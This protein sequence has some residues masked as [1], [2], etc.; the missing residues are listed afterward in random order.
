MIFPPFYHLHCDL[1]WCCAQLLC[2]AA[3][4]MAGSHTHCSSQDLAHHWHKTQA[5]N[6]QTFHFLLVICHHHLCVLEKTGWF[7]SVEWKLHFL[8]VRAERKSLV[9]RNYN[10]LNL[11]RGVC[12][13]FFIITELIFLERILASGLDCQ[14]KNINWGW[15]WI[16]DHLASLRV[17]S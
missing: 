9:S 15:K 4:S 1:W 16:L 2:V 17:C 5:F 10:G 7:K 12:F 13:V 6:A 14:E 3:A 11:V 8:W